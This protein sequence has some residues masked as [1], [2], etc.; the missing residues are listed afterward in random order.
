MLL[1]IL[2]LHRQVVRHHSGTGLAFSLGGWINYTVSD[3]RQQV[4]LP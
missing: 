1:M 4:L 3:Q 2:L